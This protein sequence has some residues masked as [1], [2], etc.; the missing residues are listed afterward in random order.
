MGHK[1]ITLSIL[2]PAYNEEENI[3]QR[4]RSIANGLAEGGVKDYEIVPIN[5][6]SQESLIRKS[7][8][9]GSR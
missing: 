6:S 2:I 8:Q 4:V 1:A 7:K 9:Y 3:V 5:D